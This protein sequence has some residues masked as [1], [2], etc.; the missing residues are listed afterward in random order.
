MHGDGSSVAS[1]EDHNQLPSVESCSDFLQTKPPIRWCRTFIDIDDGEPLVFLKRASSEP[2]LN[3]ECSSQNSHV[4]GSDRAYVE[5][6]SNKMSSLWGTKGCQIG[7]CGGSATPSEDSLDM[8]TADRGRRCGHYATNAD[9][10]RE[11]RFFPAEVH[12]TF[13]SGVPTDTQ[14]SKVHLSLESAEEAS[15][16]CIHCHM[17]HGRLALHTDVTVAAPLAAVPPMREQGQTRGALAN[18]MVADLLLRAKAGRQDAQHGTIHTPLLINRGSKGHPELC[19]RPCLYYTAGKCSNGIACEFC[20]LPHAKRP[21]HLD[22]NNRSMLQKMPFDAVITLVLPLVREKMQALKVS[23]ATSRILDAWEELFHEHSDC[24]DSGHSAA[25]CQHKASEVLDSD[26]KAQCGS[27]SQSLK[28]QQRNERRL[29]A[30]LKSMSL[31]LLLD[32]VSSC[33]LPE[34]PQTLQAI[35]NLLHHLLK[36][37][38]AH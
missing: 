20:H 12:Q 30:A 26:H 8:H 9:I 32:S 25:I 11:T 13:H 23:P 22:K 31:G 36:T 19:T 37:N 28:R 16:V 27:P 35:H 29:V 5:N 10:C 4:F 33:V 2:D 15:D 21:S 38:V 34:S 6:L 14:E 7:L 17:L 3:S 1:S 18:G 24:P